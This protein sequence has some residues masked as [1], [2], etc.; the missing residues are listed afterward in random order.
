MFDTEKYSFLLPA[1][2]VQYFPETQLA[3][4]RI[5]AETLFNSADA[6][7]ESKLREPIEGVPVYTVGG[8]GW[9]ITMPIKVGDSCIISFSQVGYDHWLYEDADVAGE[10]AGLPKPHLSRRFS[11]DDGFATVGFNTQ[12]RKV[13]KY[14]ATDSTWIN[15]NVDHEAGT[16]FQVITLKEDLSIVIDS[17]VSLTIN[18]P[19]V[20]VNCE[21][22]EV[23]ATTSAVLTT[24][25]STVDCDNATI[26]ASASVTIDTPQTDVTG[27]LNVAGMLNANGVANTGAMSSTGEI[28][29]DGDVK[30]SGKSLVDHTHISNGAGSPTEKPT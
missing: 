10:L 18:A 20:V 15:D 22:S 3:T 2:I 9:H 13:K 30:A 1:R 12:P 29:S 27:I 8:G 19:S 26:T 25:T 23:N 11:E 28:A 5:C 24:P 7:S 4:V 17:S 14:S 16:D 6:T 21:T